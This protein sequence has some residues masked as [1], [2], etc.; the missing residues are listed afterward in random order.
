MLSISQLKIAGF[1]NISFGNV[2]NWCLS[3]LTKKGM[4]FIMKTLATL[5]KALF[6]TEELKLKDYIRY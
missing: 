6:K 5:T 4:C 2:E 3:F 1:Y